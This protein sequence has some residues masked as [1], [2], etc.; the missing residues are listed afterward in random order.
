MPGRRRHY[1]ASGKVTWSHLRG[2]LCAIQRKLS[3]NN[4]WLPIFYGSPPEFHVTEGNFVKGFWKAFY[5]QFH[6]CVSWTGGI[7]RCKVSVITESIWFPK[8]ERW[9]IIGQRNSVTRDF[10]QLCIL[11]YRKN[12][13]TPKSD[14]SLSFSWRILFTA[15]LLF[16]PLSFAFYNSYLI[17]LYCGIVKQGPNSMNTT[18]TLQGYDGSNDFN[19]G[20]NQDIA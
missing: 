20:H 8:H 12:K 13:L 14:N 6:C 2:I 11:M 17:H 18:G 5:F 4:S 3:S 15:I 10:D 7:K 16:W 9:K 1:T 19:S